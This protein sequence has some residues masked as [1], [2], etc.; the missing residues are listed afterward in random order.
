MSL[1]WRRE[2]HNGNDITATRAGIPALDQLASTLPRGGLLVDFLGELLLCRLQ[3]PEDLHRTAIRRTRGQ[4][5][6]D[7]HLLALYLRREEE[8]DPA[9]GEQTQRNEKQ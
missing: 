6:V 2:L 8:L 3:L 9:A 7:V 5:D 4:T 1:V